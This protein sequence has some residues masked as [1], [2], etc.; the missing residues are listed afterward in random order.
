MANKN[1][2]YKVYRK[3]TTEDNGISWVETDEYRIVLVEENSKDCIT[4]T[5]TN[6][7]WVETTGFICANKNKYAKEIKQISTDG[8]KTWTNTSEYRQGKLI[9]E[10]SNDCGYTEVQYRWVVINDNSRYVCVGTEKHKMEIRQL[11]NDGGIT[12]AN[13]SP[14]E[15]RASDEIIE[16]YSFDCGAAIKYK[17]VDTGF[18]CGS[19]LSSDAKIVDEAPGELTKETVYRWVVAQGAKDYICDDNDVKYYLYVRQQSTDGGITWSEVQPRETQKGAVMTNDSY[20]CAMCNTKV[21]YKDGT[22]KKF[23]IN[24]EISQYLIDKFDKATSIDIGNCVTGFTKQY[25]FINNYSLSSVTIPDSVVNMSTSTFSNCSGLTFVNIPN[26]AT[27]TGD[28]T[29]AVCTSLSSITIP[30][31]V[32]SI[33]EWSFYNSGLKFVKIPD[34]VTIIDEKSFLRCS[35]LKSVSISDSVTNIFVGAFSGCKSLTFIKIPNSITS[36]SDITFED[37]SGLTE[38]IIPDS[39]KRICAGAFRNCSSLESIT[40]P[41]SVIDIEPEAFNYCI[42]LKSFT[43]PNSIKCISSLAFNYCSSLKSVTIGNG[44]KIIRQE[45]FKDCTSLSTFN[46]EGT[47]SQWCSIIKGEDWNS[48]VPATVV[49]CKDGDINISCTTT[50]DIGTTIGKTKVTY[51]DG[52]TKEFSING[53]ITSGSVENITAATSVDIGNSVL[54]IGEN[55]FENCTSLASVNIPDSVISINGGQLFNNCPNLSSVR[56]GSGITTINV[57]MFWSCSGLTSVNIPNSVTRINDFAFRD[58]YSLKSIEIPNSIINIEDYTFTRCSGLT[59]VVIPDSVIRIGVYAFSDCSI[60]ETIKISNSTV[61][62]DHGAFEGC[63]SVSSISIPESVTYIR[64]DAF[65]DCTSLSTFN[66]EGT[67][68]QWCS[69]IKDE[70]WHSGV[71]ATVVHCKDGDININI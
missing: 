57:A 20:V 43:I 69:I 13:V 3:Y 18:E 48:G 4:E 55:T 12:W 50:G 52:T 68:S 60:L 5:P 32:K 62:I 29:F 61:I 66:F 7:R 42:S 14:E 47:T 64:Q 27:S 25:S 35:E 33:G 59:E 9:E 36:I 31:S 16:R 11:S 6:T 23:N 40:I 17:W 22:T 67:T 58:C 54:S 65:K 30:N 26:F 37:C 71:P 44:V 53:E 34:S 24:G 1:N 39:V 21:A 46:F 28:F 2:K 10:S 63:S 19:N 49:H 15:T 51:K 8:G 41:N 38:V 70:D 56:I 45:A